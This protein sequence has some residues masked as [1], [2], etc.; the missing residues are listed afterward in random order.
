MTRASTSTDLHAALRESEV[1]GVCKIFP[2]GCRIL[3]LGG[4]DGQQ[5]RAL[6][7]AGFEVTS[8]DVASRHSWVDPSFPVMNY[9]GRTIP[10]ADSS[11]DG[12][13]SSNVLEHI[14]DLRYS[15]SELRRVLRSGGVGVHILPTPVWRFWTTLAHYPWLLRRTFIKAARGPRIS[16]VA[17]EPSAAA[18]GRSRLHDLRQALLLGL[19]AHGEYPNALAELHYFRRVTWERTFKANGFDVE[20]STTGIFYTGQ[21]LIPTLPVAARRTLARVLGSACHVFITRVANRTS[22]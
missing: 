17:S 14:P 1:E 10:F 6:A 18:A 5:A 8:I 15:L 13:F 12:V 19:A 3:E 2:Q 9:D 20:H 4:G 16:S 21:L 11:F 7:N 22:F